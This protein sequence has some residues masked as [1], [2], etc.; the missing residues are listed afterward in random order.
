MVADPPRGGVGRCAVLVRVQE[1]VQ[2]QGTVKGRVSER[3]LA[4]DLMSVTER[5]TQ[6]HQLLRA[7]LRLLEAAVRM[8]PDAEAVLGEMCSL[9]ARMLEEHIRHEVETLR[10]YRNRIEALRRE[11]MA[12]DHADQQI[13]LRDVNSLLLRGRH[14]PIS[15][16]VLPL[17][18]LIE[19]LREHMDEEERAMFPLVDRI[20]EACEREV[21][22]ASH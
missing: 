1:R 13:V 17:G 11:Q 6:D 19:E 9:F 5:L 15:K 18:H 22:D 12:H 7:E 2:A 10:P 4:R 14:T 20:A 8:G 3:G 16:V 21:W